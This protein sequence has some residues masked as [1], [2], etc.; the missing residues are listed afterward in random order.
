MANNLKTTVEVSICDDSNSV[1]ERRYAVVKSSFLNQNV[2]IVIDDKTTI[3]NASEL[4][5]AIDKCTL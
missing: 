1:Q 2:E 5:K 4:R 3:L